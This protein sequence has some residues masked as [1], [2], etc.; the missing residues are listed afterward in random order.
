[1]SMPVRVWIE[2]CSVPARW[3]SSDVMLLAEEPD[4]PLIRTTSCVRESGAEISAAICKMGMRNSRG[5]R[6]INI[7]RHQLFHENQQNKPLAVR[8]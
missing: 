4:L 8:P 2:G 5:Q 6:Q 3:V 7:N 1:M